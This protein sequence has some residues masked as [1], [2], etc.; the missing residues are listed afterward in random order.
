MTKMSLTRVLATTVKKVK[1]SEGQGDRSSPDRFTT[2]GTTVF[3][4]IG[5]SYLTN[6]IQL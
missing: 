3:T 2:A 5:L 4:R 6:H 1:D